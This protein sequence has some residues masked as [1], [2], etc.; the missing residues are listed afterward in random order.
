MRDQS[1][2]AIAP[3]VAR[4]SADA[5]S[6]TASAGLGDGATAGGC[7]PF[8]SRDGLYW[9]RLRVQ[10]SCWIRRGPELS[11]N[12]PVSTNA[13][14]P[15][16][17]AT[18]TVAS[19]GRASRL[20]IE[21]AALAWDEEEKTRGGHRARPPTLPQLVRTG[22]EFWVASCFRNAW[23]SNGRASRPADRRGCDLL[24]RPGVPR[25]LRHRGSTPTR[26][27]IRHAL[28]ATSCLQLATSGSSARLPAQA[29]S[30]PIAGLGGTGSGLAFCIGNLVVR[31]LG[32][33]RQERDDV[34]RRVGS[35]FT[36]I[37]ATLVST[38][39]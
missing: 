1:G 38:R 14:A 9:W 20:T 11:C 37:A 33:T 35:R 19:A 2:P 29:R 15:G 22:S 32:A 23:P 25:A 34:L 13:A 21:V 28:L 6:V 5:Q 39:S 3:A 16:P 24:T 27:E 10:S 8:G 18:L 17:S 30:S 7:W 36:P 31:R 4:R 12:L 26:V